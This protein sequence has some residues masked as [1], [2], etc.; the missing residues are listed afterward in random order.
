VPLVSTPPTAGTNGSGGTEADQLFSESKIPP[1]GDDQEQIVV[2]EDDIEVGAAPV[3]EG[4]VATTSRTPSGE[5]DSLSFKSRTG[6]ASTPPTPS[7]PAAR[8]R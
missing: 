5:H 2:E 8:R 1:P 6:A 3:I 4:A 7:T